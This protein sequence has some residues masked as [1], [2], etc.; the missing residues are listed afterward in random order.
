[1]PSLAPLALVLFVGLQ[2]QAQQADLLRMYK[3]FHANPELSFQDVEA[4]AA[5][6]LLN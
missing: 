5:I 3:C 1:M 2:V 4:A 6:D